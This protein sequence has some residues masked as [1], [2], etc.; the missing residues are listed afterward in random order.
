MRRVGIFH[1]CMIMLIL[2]PAVLFSQ[3]ESTWIQQVGGPGDDNGN[4]IVV[5]ASGFVY[6]VG[7]VAVNC[8]DIFLA[9]FD[10]EG[11]LIWRKQ[12]GGLDVDRGYALTIDADNNI[13]I[14]G[15]L[16]GSVAYFDSLEV[17]GCGNMDAFAAKYT[18]D[19]D[20]V[21]A[22]AFGGVGYD[23]ASGITALPDGGY[24]VTGWYFSREFHAVD[25]L[26]VLGDS[27]T[28][29]TKLD[30]NGNML[31]ARSGGGTG[32]N[33]SH[34]IVSDQDGNSYI[35]GFFN[36]TA[37]FGDF[38][39]ESAGK[40]DIFVAKY[41]PGGDVLWA[42]RFGGTGKDEAL[43]IA[44][45][46]LDGTL[47]LAGYVSGDASMESGE[48]LITGVNYD[49]NIFLASLTRQGEVA[50]AR[51][52][53]SPFV[54][55][56]AQA[57]YIDDEGDLFIT[58]SFS[59][60]AEIAANTLRSAGLLDVFIA[61]YNK[62]GQGV[63]VARAGGGSWND[64]GRGIAVGPNSVRYLTGTFKN[65]A[66]FETTEM[67]SGGGEDAFI[68]KL[69]EPY[70]T[71]EI[72]P[73][74]DSPQYVAAVFP[75][76]I[77]VSH[78]RSVGQ[79]SFVLSYSAY[80]YLKI[81]EPLDGAITA[82]P[83]MEEIYRVQAQAEPG[84]GRIRIIIEN[85]SDAP[86][87]TAEQV[88]ARVWFHSTVQTPFDTES[89]FLIENVTA[90]DKVG[91]Q[92]FLHPKAGSVQLVG[93][94]VWPGDTNNDGVVNEADV[95]PIGQFFNRNGYERPDR[96]NRW[97]KQLAVPWDR[98]V[99][100]TYADANGDG[101]VNQ[102]DVQ[103][104]GLNWKRAHEATLP[105]S[106]VRRPDIVRQNSTP[107]TLSFKVGQQDSNSQRWWFE[108]DI[109]EVQDLFG[110]SF[111]VNYPAAGFVKAELVKPGALMGD[112][113][114]LYHDDPRQG[115]LGI[116]M[117][118]RGD[119]GGVIGSGTIVRILFDVETSEVENLLQQLS[120]TNISANDSGGD[121][122]VVEAGKPQNVTSIEEPGFGQIPAAFQL[123]QNAPN[124]FNPSTRIS[125][126]L[127]ES[128]AVTVEIF[129]ALGRR[130]RTL[131]DA[132]QTAG[133]HSVVWNGRDDHNMQVPSGVYVFRIQA[134]PH[135]ESRKMLLV[136]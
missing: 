105:K 73:T 80:E 132:Q 44:M 97:I 131:V 10:N 17:R 106:V 90:S 87:D 25:T 95:L 33:E 11:Q 110:I 49:E 12:A 122:I 59:R 28:F 38:S 3:Q 15:G 86:G 30:H 46:P 48:L 102:A 130:I 83:G 91:K 53:G 35:A 115:K 119:E 71:G 112:P 107:A 93:V 134:G 60:T 75:V 74:V 101:V 109:S 108:L 135:A 16:D 56:R 55:D 103:P 14:A 78:V 40:S 98:A 13:V 50:W 116:G 34:G 124:P 5:D 113:L 45:S 42:E 100:V 57:V 94:G 54:A 61:R 58:G 77:K 136:K 20:V 125:Y 126:D 8:E 32:K 19:G 68:M 84:N 104:I 52:E 117:S 6:V 26:R 96:S 24:L 1:A 43:A 7:R 120:L 63:W 111:E 70:E 114:F 2:V 123:Y 4:A 36:G 79:T 118:R 82:G 65:V 18:P 9:K 22:R 89:R 27:D 47:A 128:N 51:S 23:L 81:K 69:I 76:D 37:T 127:S 31:W 62:H 133:R 99:M 21:W 72:Q 29:I 121:E 88:I 64:W 41:G 85:L 66:T 129:D 67:V 39:L 92:V